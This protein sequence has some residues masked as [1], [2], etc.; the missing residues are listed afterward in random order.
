VH[1]VDVTSAPHVLTPPEVAL[2][3]GDWVGARDGF[4][5]II[6]RGPEARAYEGLGQALWWLDD[7]LGCLE[8]RETAYRLHR[9]TED[10]AV[11]AAR[12]ATSLSCDALLFGAGAAV[13]QGWWERARDL[14]EAV[15][16]RSEH[17][18]LAVR[19][20][21]LALDID[22]DASIARAA[23]E[24]ARA[25]GRR[26]GDTQL[27]F[28]GMALSG[29]AATSAGDPATGMPQLDAAVAAATSGE[30]VDLMWM[31]KICC[32]LIAACQETQ[33]LARA[34]EWCRRVEI[35]SR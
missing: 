32:W 18:W 25:I 15:P 2:A 17:G 30:I 11:G 13:A 5:A 9:T 7:G 8:A 35:I 23:G 1:A 19:E 34:D 10:D 20:G 14:L 4:T 21:E 12:A 26:Q 3:S 33:D 16:E 31:G 29:R 27:Q 24:R 28:V 6:A 22:H